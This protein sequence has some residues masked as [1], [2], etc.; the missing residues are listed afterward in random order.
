MSKPKPNP[1]EIAKAQLVEAILANQDELARKLT[2][3]REDLELS[4]KHVSLTDLSEAVRDEVGKLAKLLKPTA[5]L[6]G[7]SGGSNTKTADKR[8]F[9]ERE[10]RKQKGG[11]L[12][13]ELL[14]LAAVE[15]NCKPAPTFLDAAIKAGKFKKI[16]EGHN[17]VV[18]LVHQQK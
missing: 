15:F 9:L 6:T 8:A 11:M 5:A 2:Q 10:L 1:L 16:R 14:E 12:K 7:Q 13:T 17:V 4:L 18:A 3:A